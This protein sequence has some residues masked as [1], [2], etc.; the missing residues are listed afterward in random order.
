MCGAHNATFVPDAILYTT[1]RIADPRNNTLRGWQCMVLAVTAKPISM[2][3]ILIMHQAV[4]AALINAPSVPEL[5]K[6]QL[7]T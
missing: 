1:A 3:P 4:I 6:H 5:L 2:M 7:P